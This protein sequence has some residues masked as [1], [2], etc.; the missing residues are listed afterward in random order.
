MTYIAMLR[1]INISGQK[2]VRMELLRETCAALGFRNVE[3]YVQ[4]G[5][6]VFLATKKPPSAL[7]KLISDAIL[8]D[9]GFSVPAL[10]K[11]SKEMDDVI[12][13]N[14]FLNERDIDTSKLHVTF[15][16]DAP[17]TNA[18]KNLEI[19]P[20]RPDRFHV[21]RQEI[22]LYCPNGYGKTKLSNTALE[23]A[24]SVVAT[25]RNWKTVNTLFEMAARR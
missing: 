20:T 1:G 15:L 18:V 17:P 8:R 23:K 24:L 10:V 11:T 4:S 12:K 14:P 7:S 21:G 3:T 13:R 22:F 2:I 6:I 19:I 9:F 25:T 5:N 16:S